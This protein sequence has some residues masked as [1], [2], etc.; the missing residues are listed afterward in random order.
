MDV[1]VRPGRAQA[2]EE[3]EDL[4]RNGSA[5]PT[6][7]EIIAR[8][9]S[10][11]DMMRGA[12]AVTAISA[13]MGPLALAAA[14][15]AEAAL[16]TTPSFKFTELD[17]PLFDERDHVAAG[18]KAQVLIR[19]GD[20]IKAGGP[21]FD[22]QA[23]TAAKQLQQF[24]YN[25]DFV[26]FFP[27]DGSSEHGLLGVNHEYTNEE[28]MFP[29]AA[30]KITKENK[31][32][33]IT[34]EIAEIEM[35][36][37]GAS[38]VE[39]RKGAAGWQ[40]VL[41]SKYNRR[42]SA[43]DTVIEVTGPAAGH[44]RLKTPEDPTGR[45]VIGMINNCAG[46]VT[47]W[48]TYLTAEENFHFYFTGKVD[49]SHPEAKNYKRVGVGSTEYAWGQFHDRFDVVKQPMAANR[50][51]WMVEIDPYDPTSTPKKRTAMGRFK[52]EGAETI[53]NADGRV[54]SYM[55]DDERFDYVY[56]FVTA[57][58]FDPANRAANMNLLDEGTLSV[59]RYDA[60]GTMEWLPLVFG[61]GPLT[62]A[63]GFASQADVV[64]E[65]RRAADLLGA[66]KMDRPED[67]QANPKTGKVYA[68]LTNN[69]R[70]KADQVDAA[71]P[72]PENLFGHIVEM[73]APGGDHTAAKYTW[74][75]LV[76][77]G[78][79]KVAAVGATFSSAT[80]E[81]GWFGMPDNCAIDHQ[82]RL[83]IATDGNSPK[84]TGRSDGLWA[85]ETAGEARG[86]SK[87]FFR[88]PLGAE[89]CGPTFTPDDRT[90]FLAIQHPGEEDA[91][92]NSGSFEAPATRWPDFAQG[93][94]PRPAVVVVTK[95]D[96]GVIA[97]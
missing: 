55:G 52:H 40:V 89:L 20:P 27:L 11:R 23:Q 49:D 63:N 18:Y 57:G 96:G 56:R 9:F 79:P 14:R 82:G 51:G 32:G 85:I 86:T 22:P 58:R 95:D 65:A 5:N 76:K 42:I 19:W 72:R 93:M 46:G 80:T 74:E 12:L 29:G 35:A 90:L 84:A 34:K 37:H 77:C 48:G 78:D 97:A 60:D 13:T 69:N 73:T 41:D 54:V 30:A 50:F 67:V 66:T 8:R 62:P 64:I 43:L 21:A 59:A 70:R 94:P 1:D 45:R 44:D 15:K 75:V 71:N 87:A 38:V 17:G 16:N 2:R 47:P 25:N 83:W 10:R 24:G 53:L 91:A 26:G 31:F 88:C 36:A 68:M 3:S 28:L 92:G 61:Q 39:I 81:Q 6:M 33:Y 4:G 7:G